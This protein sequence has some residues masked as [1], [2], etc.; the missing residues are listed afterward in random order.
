MKADVGASR[1]DLA[2]QAL[3]DFAR[4]TSTDGRKDFMRAKVFCLPGHCFFRFAVQFTQRVSGEL[5]SLMTLI[6]NF[7]PSGVTS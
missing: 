1:T 3:V 4:T 5:C 7:F 6:T 2:L